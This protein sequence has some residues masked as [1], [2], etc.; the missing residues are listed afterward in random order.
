MKTKS[1]RF[2][3][4]ATL[5]LALLGT[6]LLMGQPVKA[7][8]VSN[9]DESSL[10]TSNNDGGEGGAD[11]RRQYLTERS[12]TE[13]QLIGDEYYQGGF[14]G[15]LAGYKDGSKSDAPR[16]PEDKPYPYEGDNKGEEYKLGYTDCYSSGYRYGWEKNHPIQSL[17]SYIWEVITNFFF[18][19]SP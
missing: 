17:L 7:E 18:P 15:Y 6:T 1:K 19:S 8:G 16:E 9:P 13:D 2:L 14:D 11:L 4:L 12:L 10:Y 3:N 5:C